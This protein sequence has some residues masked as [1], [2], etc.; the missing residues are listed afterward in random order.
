MP[1]SRPDPT[2]GGVPVRPESAPAEHLTQL[3]GL[4]YSHTAVSTKP[5]E[6]ARQNKYDEEDIR[7]C[8]R[9]EIFGPGVTQL[10]TGNMLMI[11][12][13]VQI[14]EDGGA[15]RKGTIVAELDISPDMWFF[16]CHFPN[17]P[18]M[19]G[20]LGLDALWQ[21]LGFYLAWLGHKGRGRALGVREVRFTGQVLPSSK[22]VTYRLDI[23]RVVVRNLVMGIADGIMSVDGKDI[24]MATALRAGFFQEAD[25]FGDNA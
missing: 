3:G 6:L 25:L 2:P 22:R 4:V 9:G 14:D 18:V 24:Y 5:S 15:Y 12:R 23:K 1:S 8:G 10:P 17:D 11:H 13:V 16:E 19:P 21:L 7:R 20:C